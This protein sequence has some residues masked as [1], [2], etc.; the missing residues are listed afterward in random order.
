[1][2]GAC[3]RVWGAYGC[4]VTRYG[5]EVGGGRGRGPL[6]RFFFR[7]GGDAG[8]RGGGWVG[9]GAQ[10]A[11]AAGLFFLLTFCFYFPI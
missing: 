2:T 11:A 9:R 7:T 10:G 1:M 5:V 3:V 8:R 4:P 6:T